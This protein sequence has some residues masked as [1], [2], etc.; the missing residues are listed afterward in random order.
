MD[1]RKSGNLYAERCE[2]GNAV[3]NYRPIDCFNLF[4]KLLTGI[5][6]EKVYDHLN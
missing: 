6:N 2:R 4:W 1:G 3:G 5:I